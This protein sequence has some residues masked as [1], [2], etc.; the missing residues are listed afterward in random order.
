MSNLPMR[1]DL[2][3]SPPKDLPKSLGAYCGRI[4][5]AAIKGTW[6]GWGHVGNVLG[7]LGYLALFAP[8]LPFVPRNA[9]LWIWSIAIAF[10][11]VR[12]WIGGAN[13][14]YRLMGG[15]GQSLELALVEIERLR[16]L[17]GRARTEIDQ[18]VDA[19]VLALR[20]GQPG[21]EA[22]VSEIHR[23]ASRIRQDIS[24]EIGAA[25]LAAGTRR[26]LGD[27]K[28]IYE[29]H[30]QIYGLWHTGLSARNARVF[31]EFKQPARLL[32]INPESRDIPSLAQDHDHSP[33]E[34]REVI[35]SVSRQ[36][37]ENGQVVKW[38]PHRVGFTLTFY[39]PTEPG[40]WILIEL[41]RP[42]LD[43]EDR[44]IR[45]IRKADDPRE[46]DGWLDEFERQW[47]IS[48]DVTLTA[49][50]LR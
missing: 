2:R 25:D 33:G 36:A 11:I 4:A 44:P 38:Y 17:L 30:S 27:L 31:S 23:T 20:Y 26:D 45:I 35:L 15:N 7:A 40:A 28:A 6:D 42:H 3:V 50:P 49:P 37:I 5:L 32:L 9:D 43:Q 29:R 41:P 39:D 46:F 34:V 47:G 24:N 19:P 48:T 13:E 8:L 10:L 22:R 18:H 16:A 21:F 1:Q 14:G 12:M